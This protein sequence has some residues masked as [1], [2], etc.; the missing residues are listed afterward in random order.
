[1]LTDDD[2]R[3]GRDQLKR[4]AKIAADERLVLGTDSAAK[5][6]QELI[7]AAVRRKFDLIRTHDRERKT[8][9]PSLESL[10]RELYEA[11]LAT[12]FSGLTVP[13]IAQLK[14][15][16]AQEWSDIASDFREWRRRVLG[17]NART[18]LVWVG[19]AVA[20]VLVYRYANDLAA[21]V[22]GE[23]LWW[24]F[25]AGFGLLCVVMLSGYVGQY[26]FGEFVWNGYRDG[27]IDGLNAG[28]DRGL[29]LTAKDAAEIQRIANEIRTDSQVI[30]LF[31]ENPVRP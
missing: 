3:E 20:G 13:Q 30:K 6:I 10:T 11:N 23:P 1:M 9:E 7:V 17:F 22:G 12:T 27:Y 14:E 26:L 25:G 16:T 8:G 24:K 4:M 28:V 18:A 2:I 19:S 15:I 29:G 21:M 5:R 31:D